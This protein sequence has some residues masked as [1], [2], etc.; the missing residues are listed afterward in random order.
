MSRR[1]TLYLFE[2]IAHLIPNFSALCSLEVAVSLLPRVGVGGLYPG[3]PV[4]WIMLHIYIS[5]IDPDLEMRKD[6]LVAFWEHILMILDD[7]IRKEVLE[8]IKKS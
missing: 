3:N 4:R 6:I 8:N 1:N 2:E 7:N 5:T